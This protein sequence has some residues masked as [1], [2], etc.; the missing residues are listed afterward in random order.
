MR[1]IYRLGMAVALL[2][3]A[4]VNAY[5]VYVPPGS[6]GPPPSPT[7]LSDSMID[8]TSEGNWTVSWD[9]NQEA[10]SYT[11]E[12]SAGGAW[13]TV[14]TGASL[15]YEI[16]GKTVS[17]DYYYRVKACSLS[18]CST[19]SAAKRVRLDYVHSSTLDIDSTSESGTYTVSWS[20]PY[21]SGA[22]HSV[23]LAQTISK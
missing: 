11:L 4:S 18:G 15:S 7:S 14:Y 10:T 13:G 2:I 12:E 22:S 23:Y 16:S 3:T 5:D 8:K 1:I 9:G 17:G 20:R 21:A 6:L 19:A